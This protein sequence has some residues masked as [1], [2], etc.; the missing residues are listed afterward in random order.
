MGKLPDSVLPPVRSEMGRTRVPIRWDGRESEL[1]ETFYSVKAA[2]QARYP[3][4][5][6]SNDAVFETAIRHLAETLQL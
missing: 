1:G 3:E 2:L 5:S 4:R 6:W